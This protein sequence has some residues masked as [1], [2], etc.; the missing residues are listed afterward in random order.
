MH[1][2]QATCTRL[3]AAQTSGTAVRAGGVTAAL[4]LETRGTQNHDCCDFPA[5]YRA[6]WGGD[7]PWLE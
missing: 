7:P 6:A 2:A 4:V 1:S 5:R 3:C